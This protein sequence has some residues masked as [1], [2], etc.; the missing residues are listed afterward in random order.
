MSCED[1]PVI[2]VDIGTSA[3]RAALFSVEGQS[4]YAVRRPRTTDLGGVFFDA[5]ALWGDVRSTLR[6]LEVADTDIASVSVS[7][8]IGTVAVDET[9]MPVANGG[10]WADVRGLASLNAE[11]QALVGRM[12]SSS[13]RP[14]TAGS[15][16]ALALDLYK[17]G[18]GDQMHVLLSPKDFVIAR[19]TGQLC[20]DIVDAAY[21]L[22]FDIRSGDWQKD[23]LAR[24]GVAPSLF[25]AV[26]QPSD[27]V[28]VVSP[29]GG[30]ACGL[31]ART[32]VIA[33]G[34]DGSV[35]LGLLLGSDERSIADIAGTTD[36]LGMLVDDAKDQPSAAIINPSLVP[37]RWT[38]GGPTGLTGGAVANWRSLVGSV[39]EGELNAIASGCDGLRVLPAMSGERFPRWNP[40][41]RGAVL[42]RNFDHGPAHLL[43]AAQEA[44]CF[45]VR[46]GLDLLDPSRTRPVKIAGGSVRSR[47]VAQMR[48]DS[49]GRPLLVANDPDVT[50][51]GAAGLALIAAGVVGDL[52]EARDRLCV[53]FSLIEPR[54]D[55]VARYDEIYEDWLTA[56][57]VTA[58]FDSRR[59]S[60]V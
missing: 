1:S 42:G 21:T 56:R 4:L 28:A 19:L 59:S 44:A 57:D 34:P 8:H 58:T 46:E 41:T 3:V 47:A 9:L 30:L 60:A 18:L 31:P 38:I 37:G 55:R 11:D 10:G 45:A 6:S 23:A 13:G 29:E 35:G 53:R 40:A 39:E 51:V 49:F 52:D 43:R 36:V 24:L 27:V 14:V 17:Q 7:A 33:G 20:T 5:E 48:A 32:P 54:A 15:A 2:A 22:A 16:L 26:A 50:L 25:P 12:L